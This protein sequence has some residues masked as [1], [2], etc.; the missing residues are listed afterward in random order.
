MN[1]PRPPRRSPLQALFTRGSSGRPAPIAD[2]EDATIGALIADMKQKLV[3]TDE[4][5]TVMDTFFD[6]LGTDLRFLERG[7]RVDE[8]PLAGVLTLVAEQMAGR[9]LE[10]MEMKLL[11][12]QE[13]ALSHGLLFFEGWL[14]VVLVFEDIGVGVLALGEADLRGPTL[15]GR[16]RFVTMSPR[17]PG[18]PN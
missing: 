6:Q 17:P 12:L 14:G 15:Y 13:H 4:F 7:D 18:A 16:F 9:H 8:R 1:P 5:G 10:L 3:E 11:H 2:P